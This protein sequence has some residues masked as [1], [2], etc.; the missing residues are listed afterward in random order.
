MSETSPKLR[1]EL[2]GVPAYVP[3]KPAAAGGP[4]AYKLSSNENPYPP[5]PGVLESALA[6]AGSFNRYPDMACT[7]LMNELADRFGVPLGHLATG[8]G[9]VGVAQQ[10]LQAT[11]GPGDEVIYAWRSFEAYP[12]ITQVSGATSVKVPLTDGEVHDLDAMAEAITDRT[13]LIFVCNPNNPTGTVVRRAEL[14]RFL[15]RVPSDVLVVLDEAYKEFIRDAEVP[16]GIEIYRDRPNVAV[17]RTFSKAYGLAGLRVGF[18]VAHEP[19]AAALRKTAVPFG[20]SQLAQDAAVASL[21]AEDEL[22]GR[23]GSLVAE[24]TRVSA[25]LTRQGWTVPESHANFVWLRL[26][27]RTLDFAGACERAGVV[28]RPFQGEGVRV[29]IGEGEGN[30]LFLKAAEAFRAEL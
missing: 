26:G 29:S 25:E 30:D 28:V 21:R 20:V 4:V 18:A 11:S 2:D 10:L 14:E 6:A 23:V 3:G 8:T 17:L 5:L 13:R 15:D 1:A 27:E 12:I 19:V 16:D 9:S 24:R 22:L 7:G